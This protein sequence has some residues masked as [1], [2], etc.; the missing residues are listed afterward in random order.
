[1]GVQVAEEEKKVLKFRL[2]TGERTSE[3]P[4]SGKLE[5]MIKPKKWGRA[6]NGKIK[7]RI[8]DKSAPHALEGIE[9]TPQAM[10]RIEEMLVKHNTLLEEMNQYQR[11]LDELRKTYNEEENKRIKA[12]GKLEVLEGHV[13]KQEAE[14]ERYH[15]IEK[16]YEDLKR[17]HEKISQ[18]KAELEATCA[19][20]DLKKA[21][22]ELYS[23]DGRLKL[24]ESDLKD[25]RI[26]QKQHERAKGLLLKYKIEVLHKSLILEDI[27]KKAVAN[28]ELVAVSREKHVNEFKLKKKIKEKEKPKTKSAPT[29]VGK[30][31]VPA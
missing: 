25:G 17:R 24:L 22:E 2:A 19:R 21:K 1:L 5:I 10:R 28:T 3:Q 31:A 16:E 27:L 4:R 7:L 20:E 26:N 29:K 8:L 18:E 30:K 12:E 9:G 13:K 15:Q 11:R 6:G 23:I 14:L